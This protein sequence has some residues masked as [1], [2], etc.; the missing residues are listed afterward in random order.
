M[1]N[2]N[3]ILNVI[4]INVIFLLFIYHWENLLIILFVELIKSKTAD[5]Y[6]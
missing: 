1:K 4:K 3:I 2:E 6:Y 5:D